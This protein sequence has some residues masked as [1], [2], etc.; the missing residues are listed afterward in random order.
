MRNPDGSRRDILL[1][2]K[3]NSDKSLKEYERILAMLRTTGGEMRTVGRRIDGLSIAE[4]VLQFMVQHVQTYYVHPVTKKPSR[5]QINF[6]ESLRPLVRLY[7]E[8]LAAEFGPLAFKSVR[9]A[10]VCGSWKNEKETEQYQGTKRKIGLARTTT[11]QHCGRI[12]MLFRWA[13]ENEL[14]PA[15]VYHG[16]QSVSGLRRG[17]SAA[18]ETEPVKPAN[19]ET[20]D[21]IVRELPPITGDIVR[22]LLLTGARVGEMCELKSP[23]IDRTGPVWFA[24]LDKHKTAHHGHIRT[25]CFGPQAQLIL[26]RYLKADPDAYLFSPAE[27]NKI[28]MEKKRAARKTQ[29]QPS[30]QN[31]K[32]KRPSH[33]PGERFDHNAINRAIARA[34]ERLGVDRFHVHQLRHTAALNILREHGAEAARSVL[35]HR[36]IN[37]TLHY[38]GIDIEKA[39]DTMRKIG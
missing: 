27:Q 39:K 3:H 4:L 11:N 28:L 1:P 35:G 21:A 32:K 10:M 18:R 24:T 2:G 26:N 38:S 6:K 33:K 8:T 16:L 15:S 7:G 19:P 29:V 9:E 25:I 34:A 37:M 31:R 36:Q 23:D 12:K 5:E 13:S 22:L 30:Q 20:V 17:R 14:I